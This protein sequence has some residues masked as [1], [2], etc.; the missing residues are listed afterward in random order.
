MGAG[1]GDDAAYF[2]DL[3]H[4]VTAVDFSDEALARAR[5]K[6][7]DRPGLRFIKADAFHLPPSLATEG[8]TGAFDLIVEHTF[9]C[10]IDPCR[11]N[12]LVSI[13]RRCLAE[14]GHLLAV[15]FTMDKA[16]GPPFGG[17]EWELRAR[18]QGAFRPLYWF[19]SRNSHETRVGQETLIYPEKIARL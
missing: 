1:A 9:Y 8:T 6:H 14:G 16:Q 3:G 13:W 5:A 15:F 19:R 11:R 10:A 17:S 4:L 7:G 12:E 2:A 18:L